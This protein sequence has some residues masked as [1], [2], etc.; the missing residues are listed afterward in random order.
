[1]INNS[2]KEDLIPQGRPYIDLKS[3]SILMSLI[4]WLNDEKY[5]QLTTIFN[6]FF[7]DVSI[8][9]LLKYHYLKKKKKVSITGKKEAL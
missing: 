4:L 9:N 7:L 6:V 2:H 8:T 5:F 1:M 3:V